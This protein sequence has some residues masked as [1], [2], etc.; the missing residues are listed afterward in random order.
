[1]GGQ[2]SGL[3]SESA[4]GGSDWAEKMHRMCSVEDVRHAGTIHGDRQVLTAAVKAVIGRQ[5]WRK[6][7][8]MGRRSC[9]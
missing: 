2:D 5:P 7:G 3:H 9:I 8:E 1:M 4:T 6:T